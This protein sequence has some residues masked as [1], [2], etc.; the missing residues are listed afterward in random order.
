MCGFPHKK[1]PPVTA[2]R[3]FFYP[4]RRSEKDLQPF[5]PVIHYA[6]N[7]ILRSLRRFGR[8]GKCGCKAPRVGHCE[9]AGRRISQNTRRLQA[10]LPEP[11]VAWLNEGISSGRFCCTC[12]PV[13]AGRIFSFRRET[14][15]KT[16]AVLAAG[17]GNGVQPHAGGT[18][19]RTSRASRASLKASRPTPRRSPA[20][21]TART[22]GKWPRWTG[23]MCSSPAEPGKAEPE[24]PC[25]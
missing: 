6:Q 9:A 7:C 2:G 15:E 8:Q 24:A 5:R 10:F 16:V 18:G 25:S 22:N 1:S 23:T 20:P 14:H 3:R 21:R 19:G 11:E 4:C 17:A 13:S 12:P